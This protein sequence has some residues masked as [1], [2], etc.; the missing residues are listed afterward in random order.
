VKQLLALALGFSIVA[1][2]S[3]GDLGKDAGDVASDTEV[4]R[5]ASA[6]AN[7]VIRSVGD[8]DALKA[9]LDDARQS[10]NEAAGRVQTA[11][12]RATLDALHKRLED[13]AQ[14]CP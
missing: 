6:A 3:D 2:K 12:G 13:A 8:C 9:G 7:Q 5:G 10:L 14:S 4:L 1:C 11:T